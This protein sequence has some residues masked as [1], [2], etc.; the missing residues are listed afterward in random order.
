MVD[1]LQ[2]KDSCT[3]SPSSVRLMRKWYTFLADFLIEKCIVIQWPASAHLFNKYC[4]IH[5]ENSLIILITTLSRVM[6]HLQTS[7]I[8]NYLNL[9]KS[10]FEG[11]L[12]FFF[13]NWTWVKFLIALNFTG[14]NMEHLSFHLDLQQDQ[15][16]LFTDKESASHLLQPGNRNSAESTEFYLNYKTWIEVKINK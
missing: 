8:Y 12:F 10:V 15:L 3:S 13:F 7:K 5:M 11:R 2:H 16:E 9:K 4:F 1:N 14:E 6:E